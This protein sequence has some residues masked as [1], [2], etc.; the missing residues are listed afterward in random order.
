MS[1]SRFHPLTGMDDVT[2]HS[3]KPPRVNMTEGRSSPPPKR[4]TAEAS[5]MVRATLHRMRV[6]ERPECRKGSNG[7]SPTFQELRRE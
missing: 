1:C 7:R 5:R 6:K 2:I 3:P 4:N